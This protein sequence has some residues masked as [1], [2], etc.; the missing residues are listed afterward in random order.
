[1]VW[2]LFILIGLMGYGFAALAHTWL[3]T[4]AAKIMAPPTKLAMAR[5]M[6]KAIQ[7]VSRSA[8]CW[9]VCCLL[10]S[11]Y[12]HIEPIHIC[13]NLRETTGTIVRRVC[14]CGAEVGFFNAEA[15]QFFSRRCDEVLSVALA[16]ETFINPKGGNPW[17]VVRPCIHIAGDE[18]DR[19]LIGFAIM[20]H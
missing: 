3:A 15:V 5:G 9:R 8:L 7:K 10:R 12:K 6:A 14:F 19:A 1:M 18:F 16:A 20:G 11:N 13:L 17:R 2:G 4:T